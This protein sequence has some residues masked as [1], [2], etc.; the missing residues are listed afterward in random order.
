MG[1]RYSIYPRR[2]F[3][4]KFQNISNICILAMD[5]RPGTSFVVDMYSANE[6]LENARHN[7]YLEGLETARGL[8]LSGI[9][10]IKKK[11]ISAVYDG[12]DIP[13]NQVK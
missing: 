9:E 3:W 13:K 4:T 12:K 2:H 6:A 10:L 8:I 1:D 7:G 5:V 11:G